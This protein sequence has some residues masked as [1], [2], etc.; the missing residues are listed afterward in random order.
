MTDP[1]AFLAAVATALPAVEL[2]ALATFGVEPAGP[3]DDPHERH[4]PRP[5]LIRDVEH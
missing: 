2:G 5:A 1:A 4:Q 3:L